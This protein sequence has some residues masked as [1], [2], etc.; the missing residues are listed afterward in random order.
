MGTRTTPKVLIVQG[1]GESAGLYAETLGCRA[2]CVSWGRVQL[3]IA[4]EEPSSAETRCARWQTLINALCG[5]R[6]RTN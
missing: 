1:L 3:R 6:Q 4:A 2:R 5:F